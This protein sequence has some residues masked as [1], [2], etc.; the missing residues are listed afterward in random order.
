MR[1][2]VTSPNSPGTD[3]GYTGQRQLDAGMGG[4]M[5]YKARFYSP[6]INRF[7][8]PDTIT[9]GGPQGLNRY[10]YV[11]NAPVNFNDPTGHEPKYGDGACYGINCTNAN[12]TVVAPGNGMPS[13]DDGDGVL[14][15]DSDDVAEALADD[16][17]ASYAR[18]VGFVNGL[19]NH[20]GWWTPFLSSGDF[21]TTWKFLLAFAFLWESYSYK[22]AND[23]KD[24]T[25]LMT[26]SIVNK[27]GEFYAK[28]G[29]AGLYVYLGG[30][31]ALFKSRGNMSDD[32]PRWVKGSGSYLNTWD[33]EYL[34][35]ENVWSTA[36]LNIDTSWSSLTNWSGTVGV[37]AW[38]YGVIP[39]M[40]VD[41]AKIV[42]K[43]ET[44][45]GA[46]NPMTG[47]IEPFYIVFTSK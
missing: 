11:S 18:G 13:E 4:L 32:D 43:G 22:S 28:Y 9:S 17:G 6:Y 29:I 45:K 34:G 12:G 21:D 37:G 2:N 3:F 7:I 31:E 1:T 42:W 15:P 23:W 20:N 38:D 10:S 47:Q 16:Y 39:P 14:I 5:D 26:E 30:R 36:K 24:F 8:Q 41:E 25:D 27:A 46:V 44:F 40:T 33:L 35:A 19:L